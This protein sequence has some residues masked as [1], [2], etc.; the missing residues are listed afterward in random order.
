MHLTKKLTYLQAVLLPLRIAPIPTIIQ[1]IS[2]FS[3]MLIAPIS[4]LVI[5]Y[6]IDTAL[7]LH[8]YGFAHTYRIVPPLIAIAAF[9]MISQVVDPFIGNL[10]NQRRYAKMTIALDG[11]VI[12]KQARLEFK[13]LEHPDT[14]DL[15]N[16]VCREPINQLN[17]VVHNLLRFTTNVVIIA[18]TSGI[19]LINAPLAGILLIGL[20]VPVFWLAIKTGRAGYK[21]WKDMSKI[22][23]LCENINRVLTGRATTAER[24]LFG[25]SGPLTEKYLDNYETSRKHQLR[26]NAKWYGR[27]RGMSVLVVMFSSAALFMLIPAVGSGDLS[28]GLYISLITALFALTTRISIIVPDCFVKFAREREFLRELNV[29]LELSETPDAD[30]LP[31]ASPQ[32]FERLEFKNVSFAYPGMEKLVLDNI[33]FTIE[34]GKHYAFVGINGAGKTTIAKLITRLYDEYTGEILLN[35]KSLRDCPMAELKAVVCAVFQ[36]FARYDITAAQNVSLGKINGASDEEID[37]AIQL[38]GFDEKINE[39]KDGKNTLLGKTH[40]GSVDLS[41]GQWQRLAF[42]RAIISPASVKILDEPTAALDPIAESQVYAQFEE[43]SRGTTTIFIS[44]RLASAK[45]ADVIF[46][47]DGGKV[48]EQGSHEELMARRGIYAEMFESQQSWYKSEVA[49]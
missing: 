48:A 44:H 25:Y 42:A 20:S 38:S 23:R 2:S 30:A 41:G 33:S 13:H 34:K 43:I 22:E 10:A 15:I 6:F 17:G 37:R 1:L 19:L 26:L 4:I 21:A 8:Q 40:E 11:S 16:R 36:D 32:T 46:V 49:L 35:G 7:A 12:N 14:M 3:G 47:L 45:M 5:A 31:A 27:T 39:L 18:G 24:N 9:Q 29:F 28:V